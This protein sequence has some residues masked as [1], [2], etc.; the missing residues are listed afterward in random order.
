MDYGARWIR[1]LLIFLFKLTQKNKY[2]NVKYQ[3]WCHMHN[4][5]TVRLYSL[6][7]SNIIKLGNQ[8]EEIYL[9]NETEHAVDIIMLFAF[10]HRLSIFVAFVM[11]NQYLKCEILYDIF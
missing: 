3:N 11:N 2:L 5:I 1:F 8:H 4:A 7:V 10:L 9:K 6:I